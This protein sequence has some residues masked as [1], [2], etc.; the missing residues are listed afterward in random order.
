MLKLDE[1]GESEWIQHYGGT[2]QDIF[3]ASYALEDGSYVACGG[4]GSD[5]Y[6]I[7]THAFTGSGDKLWV[8]KL[9]APEMDSVVVRT[10]ANVAAS[11]STKNG[12]LDMTATI[13]PRVLPQNVTWSIVPGTGAASINANGVV[14]AEEDGTVWAKA[15]AVNNPA[16]ADSVEI[17]ITGQEV[18]GGSVAG[19][20]GS[21]LRVN[22]YP[23]P[24]GN[25]LYLQLDG[26]HPQLNLSIVNVDGKMVYR[27]LIPANGL[28]GSVQLNIAN[29][30]S[31][32][33]LV[34]LE[35]NDIRFSRTIAKQ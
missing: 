32:I 33:Y 19:L 17:T 5:D 12:T 13:Y 35:G 2:S 26:H 24:T 15:V 18:I 9:D 27:D 34:Q 1:Q 22:V 23:N 7:P 25:T 4:A 31:G 6:D 28:N 20:R 29:L 16:M 21:D 3:F 14:T 30:T 8:L 10:K 11:I